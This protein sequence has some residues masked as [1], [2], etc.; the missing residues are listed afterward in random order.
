MKCPKCSDSELREMALPENLTIDM[1][2]RCKGIWYDRG[3]IGFQQELERDVPELEKVGKTRR[4]TCHDCPRCADGTKLEEMRYAIQ[5]D[6]MID[7]CPKC[8]GIFLDKG[9]LRKLES[10]AAKMDSFS[11]RVARAI[12]DIDARGYFK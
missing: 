3:E 9:E 2:P 5:A 10:I 8:E 4:P 6:L 11:A 12:K 1:C 7:R